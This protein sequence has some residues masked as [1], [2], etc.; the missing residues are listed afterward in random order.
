VKS[1]GYRECGATW[2][3][4]ERRLDQAPVVN[5]E[6]FLGSLGSGTQ[7][8]GAESALTDA[9]GV[10]RGGAYGPGLNSLLNPLRGDAGLER[11]L[12]A[13]HLQPRQFQQA[14]LL[15]YCEAKFNVCIA[16][17]QN[18]AQGCLL[19]VS[20]GLALL[21]VICG[22]VCVVG[23]AI[24]LGSACWKCLLGSAG[25]AGAAIGFCV[26]SANQQKDR[27]LEDWAACSGL[28]AAIPVPIVPVSA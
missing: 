13:L 27:C 16:K 12:A 11:D 2:S 17:A 15:D 6:P 25:G 26:V 22:A 9:M 1:T 3:V 5:G 28:T 24:A 7:R 18:W 19:G 10:L 14:S 23:G 20:A 8:I 4:L 21:L